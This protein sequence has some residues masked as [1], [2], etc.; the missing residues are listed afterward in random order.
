MS[1]ARAELDDAR[2]RIDR[3]GHHRGRIYAVL[4]VGAGVAAASWFTITQEI[5]SG[6]TEPG[7]YNLF[8]MLL[9]GAAVIATSALCI[10]I[11]VGYRLAR[12]RQTLKRNSTTSPSAIT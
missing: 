6:A 5:A 11:E 2:T 12:W 4:V 3:F 7:A 1:Q 9:T 10:C 8:R